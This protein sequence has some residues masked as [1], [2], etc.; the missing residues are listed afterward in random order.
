MTGIFLQPIADAIRIARRT[1]VIVRQNIIISLAYNLL[2]VPLAV[3]GHVTPLIAA[4]AMSASSLT[5]VLNAIRLRR[6]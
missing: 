2:A 3:M 4:V 5:V 1:E 6:A